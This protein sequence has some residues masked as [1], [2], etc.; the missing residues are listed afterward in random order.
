MAQ[1]LNALFAPLDV[2]WVGIHAPIEVIEKRERARG[3]RT[4][5][6]A[7]FHLKMHDY[8]RNDFEVD[9]SAPQTAVVAALLL[10]GGQWLT[11]HWAPD[12]R[13]G[14]GHSPRR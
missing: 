13:V 6:E 11:R 3:N 8:C 1:R 12:S 9:T 5:S 2:F 14:G 4:I 7:S 10:A